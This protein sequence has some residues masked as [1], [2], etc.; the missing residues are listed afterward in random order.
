MHRIA[1]A[2]RRQ[3]ADTAEVEELARHPSDL[4]QFWAKCPDPVLMMRVAGAAGLDPRWSV[5]AACDCSAAVMGYIGPD[6]PRP[7]HALETAQSWLEKAVSATECEKAA[8]GAEEAALAYREARK[9]VDKPQRR[10]YRAAAYASYASS[11]AASTA[12]DA[13]LTTEL[14]YDEEYT[15]ED[16]WDGARISCAE[17]AAA[18]VKD[19]VE[20]AVS[21]TAARVTQETGSYVAGGA[22]AHE[23][24]PSAMKW[25][26]D[27]VRARIP[28]DAIT[29]SADAVLGP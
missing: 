8:T 26:A 23:A 3:G 4:A 17:G 5:A 19:V 2:L 24:R 14:D 20:A 10:T 15:F 29:A 16:A 1:E 25:A 13:A 22:A 21:A 27:L 9:K 28:A 18:V 7:R 12:R 11:K 6:E